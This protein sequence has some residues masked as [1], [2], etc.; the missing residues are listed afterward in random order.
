MR[1]L[2]NNTTI[3]SLA[4]LTIGFGV[5]SSSESA[6]ATYN[7]STTQSVAGSHNPPNPLLPSS[8]EMGTIDASVPI[9]PAGQGDV[10]CHLLSNHKSFDCN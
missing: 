4:A 8:D 1:N 10:N 5:A 7:Q 6:F 3:A 2:I 9:M